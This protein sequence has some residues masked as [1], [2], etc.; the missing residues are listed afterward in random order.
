MP[1]EARPIISFLE[2]Q[3]DWTHAFIKGITGTMNGVEILV[4]QSGIGKVAAA[5]CTAEVIRTYSP[6]L[7]LNIGVSGGLAE[8]TK[9]G[10][11]VLADRVGYHDVSCGE[12]IPWGQVQG[13]PQFFLPSKEVL[14]IILREN[15][16]TEKGLVLCGDRFLSDPREHEFISKTFPEVFAID[17][18]S[19]AIAQTAFLYKIPFAVIRGISDTPGRGDSYQQYLKFWRE[20]ELYSNCFEAIQ[21]ILHSITKLS[22]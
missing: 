11:I 15:P 3:K 17:M 13:F 22:Q 9:Q 5:V 2:N 10:T 1:K 18:E 4:A 6:D 20:K 8:E 19:A 14:E 21:K 7:V 12:E 16:Q